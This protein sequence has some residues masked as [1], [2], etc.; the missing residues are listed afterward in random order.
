[1]LGTWREKALDVTGHAL[2]CGHSLQE[3]LP[4]ETAEA[5]LAFMKQRSA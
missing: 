2:P 5:I 1:V 4:I 3:E